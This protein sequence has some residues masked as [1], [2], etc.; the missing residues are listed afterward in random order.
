MKKSE[1]YVNPTFDLIF[2]PVIVWIVWLYAVFILRIV[3]VFFTGTETSVS[4]VSVDSDIV[5]AVL[6]AAWHAWVWRKKAFVKASL[7]AAIQW[8]VLTTIV[9]YLFL[10]FV[11]SI[12]HEQILVMM[13]FWD[14]GLVGFLALVFAV[15]PLIL[16]PVFGLSWYFRSQMMVPRP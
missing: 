11:W 7:I 4:E 12:P 3:I 8:P 2:S 6:V 9:S 10:M 15:A 16:G 1:I 5:I 13:R 14:G